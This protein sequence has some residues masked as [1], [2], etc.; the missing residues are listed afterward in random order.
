MQVQ[1]NREEEMEIDLRDLFVT[2]VKHWRRALVWAAILAVLMGG[3]R[4][5]R[6]YNSYKS[7]M[8]DEQE[9]LENSFELWEY[10][11]NKAKLEE[12][13]SRTEE[14]RD[15]IAEYQRDSMLMNLDPYDYYWAAATYYVTTNYQINPELGLQDVN[16]TDSVLA[17]YARMVVDNALYDQIRTLLGMDSDDRYVSEMFRFDVSYDA[18]MITIEAVGA[19]EAKAKEL[20]SVISGKMLS[21][22]D[23]ITREIHQHDIKAITEKTE[24]INYDDANSS[25]SIK[26]RATQEAYTDE[27]LNLN[28]KLLENQEDLINLKK[29]SPIVT[30]N[31]SGVIKYAIVGFVGGIFLVCFW[32]AVVYVLGGSV[33][34]EEELRSVYGLPILGRIYYD[35]KPKSRIDAK[36]CHMEHGDLIARTKEQISELMVA[37]M[38]AMVAEPGESIALV[39]TIPDE[40]LKAVCQV[41]KGKGARNLVCAGNPLLDAPAMEAVTSADHILIVE[42]LGASRRTE[43]QSEMELLSSLSKDVLGILLV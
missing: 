33:K 5:L 6:A 39:G 30:F 8:M 22:S 12:T 36:I 28:Q 35:E 38:S 2:V 15:Q 18:D 41:F 4:L 3:Y 20:L 37:K 19:T 10:E 24:H 13:I 29:E 16:Y 43:I 14:K 23:T 40:A 21:T 27:Y 32:Y 17:A 11:Q 31:A 9:K 26:V 42:K 25:A 1:L 34:T 7:Q